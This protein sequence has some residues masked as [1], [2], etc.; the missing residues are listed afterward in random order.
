[1]KELYLPENFE[2]LAQ[3][4]FKTWRP[5][6]CTEDTENLPIQRAVYLA[7]NNPEGPQLIQRV[8]DIARGVY[9]HC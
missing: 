5:T 9:A 7:G 2:K 1:M 8:S 3:L 4:L 6:E